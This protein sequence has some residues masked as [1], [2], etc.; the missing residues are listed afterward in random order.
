MYALVAAILFLLSFV[1]ITGDGTRGPFIFAM[2]CIL[3]VI[4]MIR[5]LGMHHLLLLAIGLFV[6]TIC[7]GLAPGRIIVCD[8]D[9]GI[10][11]AIQKVLKRIA[12]SNGINSVYVFEFV[13]SGIFDYG[14]GEVHRLRVVASLPGVQFGEV[15]LAGRE[16]FE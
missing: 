5:R 15:P 1:F 2:L 14:Y 12:I 13:R 4:S 10:T 6:I 3:I 11:F 9:R 7:I 8:Q 16:Q